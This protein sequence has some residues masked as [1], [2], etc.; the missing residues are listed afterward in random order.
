MLRE[1]MERVMASYVYLPFRG[2][3]ILRESLPQLSN[4]RFSLFPDMVA[5]PEEDFANVDHCGFIVLNLASK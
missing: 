5:F 2:L 4:K 3:P 1:E